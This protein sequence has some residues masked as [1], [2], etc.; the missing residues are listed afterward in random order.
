M[1]VNDLPIT[2]PEDDILNRSLFAKEL[3]NIIS[4]Y[5]AASSL[6]LGLY[7]KWGS[8]KTSFLNMVFGYL[9]ANEKTIKIQFSPWMF[10]DEYQLM[11]Q[12]FKQ[13]S[14]KTKTKEYAEHWKKIGKS[15]LAYGKFLLP[16]KLEAFSSVVNTGAQL[17]NYIN[18]PRMSLHEKKQRIIED[19]GKNDLKLI[20]F[21]DDIER[22]SDRE[23]V[24]VF[25]L[26]KSICDFPNMIYVLSFDYDIVVKALNNVQHGD[27]RS[28]LEKVIQVPFEIPMAKKDI[29]HD[30]F[31][32]NLQSIVGRIDSKW[33]ERKWQ[34]LFSY[35]VSHYVNSIR[36]VNRFTNLLEIRYKS[37]LDEYDPVDIIGIVCL[38]I[39]EPYIFS[40]VPKYKEFLCNP[41]FNFP[42]RNKSDD[43]EFNSAINILVPDD[44]TVLNRD[45]AL[46]IIGILFPR[47]GSY[48]K[49]PMIIGGITENR[50][51]TRFNSICESIYFDRYFSLVLEDDAIPTSVIKQVVWEFDEDKIS[52]TVVMLKDEGRVKHI[53]SVISSYASV[54]DSTV[55]SNIRARTLI[56][57]L[58]KFYNTVEYLKNGFFEMPFS[59]TLFSCI[60][61]LL[62]IIKNSEDV[63]NFLQN[64]FSAENIN[65]STISV[66]VDNL[67]YRIY[68]D[69]GS[70][71]SLTPLLSKEQYEDLKEVFIER[72]KKSL[73]DGSAF[74]Q[75]HGLDVI[76]SLDSIDISLLSDMK[77]VLVTDRYRLSK[78]IN[79]CTSTIWSSNGSVYKK[80][81]FDQIEEFIGVEA[82]YDM[83]HRFIQEESFDSLD[84]NSKINIV[85]FI[86]EKEKKYKDVFRGREIPLTVLKDE[87]NKINHM[88]CTNGEAND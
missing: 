10:A 8:G 72:A 39:F 76:Y 20:V 41:E 14:E 5:K 21:I 18:I 48:L 56:N 38:Q 26:V 11:E 31:L 36:D 87:L 12:F 77:K 40:N 74:E 25:K 6:T 2:R 65:P 81:N 34:D 51:S 71:V 82:A 83:M 64:V 33:L 75:P 45:A 84:E 66:L 1:I 53:L 37:C 30:K 59:V 15:I 55:I 9:E 73:M 63:F 24:A 17:L 86:L 35:G 69:D 79:L 47:I 62:E 60:A 3:A 70:R 46:Y 67:K 80:T 7:G 23:I 88:K 19:L 32:S 54:K 61:L 58:L 16:T 49:I 28:Y 22:L 85:S 4:N 57:G 42:S 27:G 13:I 44:S 78:I 29:I 50:E 52:S 68:N 43:K